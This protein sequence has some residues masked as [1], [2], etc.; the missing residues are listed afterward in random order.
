VKKYFYFP[1]IFVLFAQ[2][3]FTHLQALDLQSRGNDKH[4]IGCH[5]KAGLFS[6]FLSVLNDLTWCERNGKIPVVYWKSSH[7]VYYQKKKYNGA[8]NPW[9]YYFLPVSNLSYNKRDKINNQCAAPDGSTI[10]PSGPIWL[11]TQTQRMWVNE[12]LIE[13]YIKLHP[14]IQQKINDFYQTHFE[15]KKT[16]GIHLRGTDKFTEEKPVPI[17]KI[18]EEANRHKNCQYFIA[19]DEEK[20]LKTAIKTLHGKVIYHSSTRSTNGQPVHLRKTN[21]AKL[22]EEVL[23]E[24]YLLSNCDYFIHTVSNVSTAVLLLNPELKSTLMR[25]DNSEMITEHF[26]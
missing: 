7:C 26:P 23:I 15:G 24:A 9:E 16:V 20:L 5:S 1:L 3:F 12:A 2:F 8:K 11:L 22:G 18:F 17:L 19:T 21:R 10:F 4:V 25:M 14:S 6:L 13:K